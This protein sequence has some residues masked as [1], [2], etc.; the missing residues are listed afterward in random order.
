MNKDYTTIHLVYCKM[1]RK[2]VLKFSLP[3]KYSNFYWI[4]KTSVL[5]LRY[6]WLVP[7]GFFS[8]DDTEAA[9]TF[10]KV[11]AALNS[12][13]RFAHSYNAAVNKKFGFSE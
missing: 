4:D 3:L 5:S 10:Q 11:A 12:D 8:S 2:E 9:K 13:I 6:I 1:F 7:P